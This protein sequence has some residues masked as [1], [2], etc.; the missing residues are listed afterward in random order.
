MKLSWFTLHPACAQ[1]LSHVRLFV[2]LWA[3]AHLAPQSTRFSRQEYWS[4]L[5]FL[6]PGNLPDLGIK[7]KSPAWQ[8]DSLPLLDQG[9]LITF[10]CHLDPIR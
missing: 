3:V 9:G 4:G 6:P 7:S 5:P 10:N 2:I 8:E 1:S